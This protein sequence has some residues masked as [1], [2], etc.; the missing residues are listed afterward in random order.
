ME[1]PS[2][3]FFFPA[4]NKMDDDFN[5]INSPIQ[6]TNYFLYKNKKYPFNLNFFAFFSEYFADIQDSIDKD[7]YI[8]LEDKNDV[9][10][11]H[12]DA[13]FDF[14]RYCQNQGIH[15]INQD[16]VLTLNYL[17]NKYK[18]KS[19]VTIT[20]KYMRNHENQYLIHLLV[21]TK[22]PEQI[23]IYEDLLSKSLLNYIKDE[24]FFLIPISS[25]YRIVTKY[26]V[27]LQ[28]ENIQKL[29]EFLF[30]CLDKYGT[31]ASVL[32]DEIDFSQFKTECFHRLLTKYSDIFGFHFVNSSFIKTIYD[33][34]SE[35]LRKEEI[36]QTKQENVLKEIND[37][38][39]NFN[40]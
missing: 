3:I 28:N 18:V 19:L 10:T 17:A 5:D 15:S 22:M 13:I 29:I 35:I 8:N 36:I 16:N 26:R 14:I 34:Q 37:V 2:W 24:E 40:Q 39:E 9:F 38:I 11:L 27:N 30:K 12:E 32:F 6:I 21:N 1:I 23:Q 31:K 4:S 7:Q 33:I 25:L 20:E